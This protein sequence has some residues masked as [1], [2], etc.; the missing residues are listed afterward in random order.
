MTRP[1]VQSFRARIRRQTGRFDRAKQWYSS[2]VPNQTREARCS[3]RSGAPFGEPMKT[4]DSTQTMRTAG[5]RIDPSA[6]LL[7]PEQVVTSPETGSRYEVQRFLGAGGFGQA[8]L[9][10]RLG[11]ST[12][13]PNLVC[14]KVSVRID[15][16]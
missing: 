9:V 12:R 15:G 13:V 5:G 11:R 8:Y 6:R 1:P 4:S 14:L 16:W 3:H 10:H 2:A 7:V